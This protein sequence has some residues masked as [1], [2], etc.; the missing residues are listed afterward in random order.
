MKGRELRNDGGGS[1]T[2]NE[3]GS[4]LESNDKGKAIIW[5]D[6]EA[7]IKALES[8]R[9]TT[10]WRRGWPAGWKSGDCIVLDVGV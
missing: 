7:A 6:A 2:T 10:T 8:D 1:G 3:L 5:L 9:Q 4:A